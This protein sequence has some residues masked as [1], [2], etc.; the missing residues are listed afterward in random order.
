MA[1]EG[2]KIR[3]FDLWTEN[4]HGNRGV[5]Y[6]ATLRMKETL[7]FSL[8]VG[9]LTFEGDNPRDLEHQAKMQLEDQ[10]D[11]TWGAIILID[12]DLEDGRLSFRRLFQAKA[13][14]G[15]SVWRCWRFDGDNERETSRWWRSEEIK[16]IGLLEGGIPGDRAAGPKLKER[17]LPYTS[18]RWAAIVKLD[19]MLDQAQKAI[20]QK[21]SDI[22]QAGD[23]DGFLARA[24]E[25]G[26]PRII[27]DE[28]T[29][30]K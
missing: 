6:T 9:G 18:A 2:K 30:G 12:P 28:P 8:E 3:E 11:L 5:S 15:K 14:S 24:T 23:L 29:K 20:A 7:K 21:L 4:E 13:R 10:H 19:E 25:Q 26:V 16:T 1:R 22:I 27:F 17:N